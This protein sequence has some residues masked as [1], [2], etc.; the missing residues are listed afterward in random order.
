MQAVA[1]IFSELEFIR[2]KEKKESVHE[3]V[4]KPSHIS[5]AARMRGQDLLG[6]NLISEA[7]MSVDRSEQTLDDI[8]QEKGWYSSQ[9]PERLRQVADQGIAN[10]G[11]LVGKYFRGNKKG[12]STILKN[13]LKDNPDVDVLKLKE[14][15]LKTLDEMAAKEQ[16]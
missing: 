16:K 4:L 1:Y 5:E 14:Q 3:L 11:K 12:F 2:K 6:V 10:H 15:L 7:I 13:T 9:D 8:C